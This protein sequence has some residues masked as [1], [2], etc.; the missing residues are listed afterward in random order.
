VPFRKTASNVPLEGSSTGAEV[1]ALL[2][3]HQ[4]VSLDELE[5]RLQELGVTRHTR[6]GSML[7]AYLTNDALRELASYAAVHPKAR[8]QLRK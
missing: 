1:S 5:Q 3:P 4:G 7:S 8:K 6:V 2:E